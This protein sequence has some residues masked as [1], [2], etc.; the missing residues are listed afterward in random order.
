[1]SVATCIAAVT[2]IVEAASVIFA[3]LEH[4]PI[5]GSALFRREGG[6]K[7]PQRVEDVVEVGFPVGNDPAALFEAFH[8]ARALPGIACAVIEGTALDAIPIPLARFIAKRRCEIGPSAFLRPGDTQL[9]VQICQTPFEAVLRGACVA[10]VVL[11]IGLRILLP[12]ERTVLIW[13]CGW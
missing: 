8:H 3:R 5:G 12:I 2:G 9:T 13:R 11:A 4:Q 10:P 1:V 7:R 6:I